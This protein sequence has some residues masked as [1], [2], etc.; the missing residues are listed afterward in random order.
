MLKPSRR[1][2]AFKLNAAWAAK[3]LTVPILVNN[4]TKRPL[5]L[6]ELFDRESLFQWSKL[7]LKKFMW[8]VSISQF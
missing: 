1:A 5:K 6:D 4:L 7:S 2:R 3:N 8:E